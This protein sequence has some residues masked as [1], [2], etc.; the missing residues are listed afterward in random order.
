MPDLA[1]FSATLG[2]APP[3]AAFAAAAGGAAAA[4]ALMTVAATDLGERRIGN[5]GV[6][7][8]ALGALPFLALAGP[9]AAFA[10]VAVALLLFAAGA[11]AFRAGLVG[12]GDVKLLA[13]AALW[14][15]PEG[16]PLLF[17]VQ[18][19]ATFLLVPLVLLGTRWL[20]GGPQAGAARPTLPLGVAIAA[21]GLAV[22]L[23]RLGYLGG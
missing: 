23:G 2:T 5:G 10:H 3:A 17:L 6:L 9:S 20:A 15:G 21:G 12:G 8:V 14:A 1:T 7:A 22:I 4:A 18:A 19:L 11:L 16:L 13:A